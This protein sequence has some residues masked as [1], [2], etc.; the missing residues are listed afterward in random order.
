M[1]TEPKLPVPPLAQIVELEQ[2][3]ARRGEL[4][5][6]VATCGGYDP[7]HPGHLSCIVD[8]SRYGDTLVVF[9]NGDEFLVG[10]K[11][12]AFQ[13]C[14]T[15]CRIV[16][17]CRGVDY[18]VP[19][20]IPGDSTMIEALRALRPH[21]FT[22]GGDRSDASNIPEWDICQEHDIEI[23]TGV[24]LDKEWSS[25]NFL[26]DWESYLREQGRI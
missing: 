12:K 25:S 2:L 3:T 24:G 26:A 10:K 18:V 1:S 5:K 14:D 9:V 6:I 16:S 7:I 19:F 20:G 4:G 22:K 23:V 15:R 11:G 8:S 13:D 21:V 17:Y